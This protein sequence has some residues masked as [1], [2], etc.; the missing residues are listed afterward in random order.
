MEVF[1]LRN[2]LIEA[3]REYASSFIRIRDKRIKARVDEAFDTGR[4]WPHPQL[5]LNPAFESGGSIRQLVEEGLIHP[6]C[7]QIFR[8]GKS[9]A[10]KTGREMT[11]HRH[12][13]DAIRAASD[14]RTA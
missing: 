12:Q 11:L 8:I 14:D 13:V 7:E 3:Y 10:D 5:G 1:E 2:K 4:L 6:D 9:D